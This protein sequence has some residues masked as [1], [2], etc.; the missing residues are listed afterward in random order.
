MIF[1]RLAKVSRKSVAISAER[2]RTEEARKDYFSPP[3][4]A[5]RDSVF[6]DYMT[7]LYFDVSGDVE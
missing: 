2:M 5:R 7:N 4:V 1:V 6:I 3:H